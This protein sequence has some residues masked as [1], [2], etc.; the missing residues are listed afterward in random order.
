MFDVEKL[1]KSIIAFVNFFTVRIVVT[2]L[3]AIMIYWMTGTHYFDLA[4][5][6]IRQGP[7]TAA[8]LTA[9]ISAAG[10]YLTESNVKNALFVAALIMSLS[11]LDVVYRV[12]RNVGRVLPVTMIYEYTYSTNFLRQSIQEAWRFYSKKF[13]LHAFNS[14]VADRASAELAKTRRMMWWQ[15]GFSFA[16]SFIVMM[17][18]LYIVTPRAAL[19]VSFW[20]VLYYVV[21]AVIFMAVCTMIESARYANDMNAAL[22]VATLALISEAKDPAISR[23]ELEAAQRQIPLPSPGPLRWRSRFFCV[24]MTISVPYFGSVR[25]WAPRIWRQIKERRESGW[26]PRKDRP[27]AP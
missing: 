2:C 11:L 22:R 20:T 15:T 13:E 7:I 21:L 25:E 27:L 24:G 19:Q 1:V 14:F 6:Y 3:L 17:V 9:Y 23:A 5:T 4:A 8:D 18:L 26:A 12:V 16:K 10:V